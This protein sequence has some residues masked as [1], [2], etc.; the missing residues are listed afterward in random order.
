MKQDELNNYFS[1]KWK[2]NLGQYQYSGWALANK[3]RANESVLDVGC[4][5]NEFKPRISN[6]TGLDPA[7]DLADIKLPIEE[8]SPPHKF[9]VALCLGSINFG[10][11]LTIMNQIACVVNCLKP[12]AR[13]YW[14]CNPGLADHGNE[15]CKNIDFYPWSIDEHVKLSELFGFRLIICCWDNDRIYAEWSRSA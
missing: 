6:L 8:Y 13:I 4:G 11:K 1:T 7:N 10:N 9:D 14:R 3:I 2:S 5:F 12:T 15:E